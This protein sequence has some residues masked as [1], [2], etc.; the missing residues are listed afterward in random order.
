MT[1]LDQGRG[2]VLVRNEIK[3]TRGA[4]GGRTRIF[5]LRAEAAPAEPG[6][7]PSPASTASDTSPS[8]ELLISSSPRVNPPDADDSGSVVGVGGVQMGKW[9]RAKFAS[10]SSPAVAKAADEGGSRPVF[11]CLGGRGLRSLGLSVLSLMGRKGVE[12]FEEEE[13]GSGAAEGEA[14][15]LKLVDGSGTLT[16][17][18]Y[19]HC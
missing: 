9:L 10:P 19:L 14:S 8:S 12:G 13:E 15:V 17:S 18:E 16:S 7:K 1:D 4:K 11:I 6:E 5:V 2:F 3:A